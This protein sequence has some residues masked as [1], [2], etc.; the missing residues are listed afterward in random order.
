MIGGIASAAGSFMSATGKIDAAKAAN[1]GGGA[2]MF[3][4]AAIGYKPSE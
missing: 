2:S 4:N 3:S 1:A